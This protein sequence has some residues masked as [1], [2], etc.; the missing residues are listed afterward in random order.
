[1]V[2]E[3]V[4]SRDNYLFSESGA[5]VP[6][7]SVVQVRPVSPSTGDG[8]EHAHLVVEY[9]STHRQEVSRVDAGGAGFEDESILGEIWAFGPVVIA[10]V[11]DIAGRW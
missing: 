1:M 7:S 2:S 11:E 6:P 8:V 10:H 4:A 3:E 9:S 5:V